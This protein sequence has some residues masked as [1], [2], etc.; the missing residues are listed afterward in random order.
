MAL[1]SRGFRAAGKKKGPAAAIPM[2]E[3]AVIIGRL[4]P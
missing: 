4:F 1:L 3:G 2:A